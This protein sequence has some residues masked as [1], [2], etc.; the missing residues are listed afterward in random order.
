MNV[1]GKKIVCTSCGAEFDE[2]LAGCPYC[3]SANLKG[4]ETEYM[5]L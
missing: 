2:E 3:G 5:K 4:E 1:M